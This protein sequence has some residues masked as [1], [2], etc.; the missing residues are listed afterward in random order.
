MALATTA[1]VAGMV[2]A[3]SRLPR[4]AGLVLVFAYAA[5]VAGSYFVGDP[6]A[7]R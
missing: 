6:E 7:V 2:A 4:W 3:T 5:F 1:F